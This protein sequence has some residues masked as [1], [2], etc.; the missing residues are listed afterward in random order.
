[1]RILG[2]LFKA[3][4]FFALFG[5][6]LNNQHAATVNWFFGYAWNA[7]MVIVVL[8]SFGLGAAFG[9]VAMSPSWWR[10]RRLASRAAAIEA[11]QVPPTVPSSARGP[12]TEIPD[13]I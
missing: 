10:Q 13:G 3:L 9:V 12:S 1:M 7:P 5:F 4:L 6:S 2:W 11:P 8:T